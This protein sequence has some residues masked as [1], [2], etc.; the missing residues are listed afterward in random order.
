MASR[1]HTH[2]GINY[3]ECAV[4]NGAGAEFLEHWSGDPQLE[5]WLTC[6]TCSGKGF[7]R[8]TPPDLL[9]LLGEQR[10]A[11]LRASHAPADSLAEFLAPRPLA[12][13]R[14][15]RA[16]AVARAALPSDIAPRAALE[17]AA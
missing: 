11:A 16:R 4:C 8:V 17:H 3:R 9:E 2:A 7:V 14:R 13:Y 6:C 15:T 10:R 5:E 1:G 12:S